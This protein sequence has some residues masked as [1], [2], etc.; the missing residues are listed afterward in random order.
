MDV[1]SPKGTSSTLEAVNNALDWVYDRA[2]NGVPGVSTV[3]EMVDSYLTGEKDCE[4]AI[5]E[6]IK[7]QI[8]KAG[9]AGFVSNLGGVITLP[10]SIPA[11]LAVVLL[12]QVRMIA[13]IAMMRGYDVKS[14]QVRTLCTACLTGSAVSDI[15]KDVGIQFGSKLTQQAIKQVA[16]AT[17]VKINQAV[18][19]RLLTKAGSTGIVNLGKA[20]PFIGG[21]VGGTFDAMTTKAIGAAA[22]HVFTAIEPTLKPN[23]SAP[24]G[25][26]SVPDQTI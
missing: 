18:G 25:V 8:G 10:V 15:L 3:Q 4:A 12:I 1:A 21:V 16:G 20:V 13:A 2:L 19:F 11:N 9:V 5:E 26:Q 6:L 17:L 24:E 14:D 7:W 23:A 22:K